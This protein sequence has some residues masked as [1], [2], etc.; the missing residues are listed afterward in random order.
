MALTSVIITIPAG[1]SLSPVGMSLI[2]GRLVRIR[3]PTAWKSAN[4][5]FQCASADVP[6]QYR[7]LYT[8]T[9]IE[10]ALQSVQPNSVIGFPADITHF[11]QEVWLKIRSGT[12]A[13]PVPQPAACDF[14]L[15]LVK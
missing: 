3:V 14:E 4:L 15:V 1:Q 11:L 9:G 10:L 5:T 2:A 13:I 12:A 7:D 6:A 8:R